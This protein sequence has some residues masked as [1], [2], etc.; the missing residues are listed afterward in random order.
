MPERLAAVVVM[1]AVACRAPVARLASPCV[2]TSEAIVVAANLDDDDRDGRIDGLQEPP[3]STDDEVHALGVSGDCQLR[4]DGAPTGEVRLWKGLDGGSPYRVDVVRGRSPSWNGVASITAPG[5]GSITLT[6]PPILLRNPNEP[7]RE[8]WVTDVTDPAF[9]ATHE[10]TLRLEAALPKPVT[11]R[12]LS[13]GGSRA[14]RWVQDAFQSAS[15]G[16]RAAVVRLPRGGPT[17]GLELLTHGDGLPADV[18]TVG[19]GVVADSRFDYGG[20]LEVLAPFDGFLNGR[21]VIGGPLDGQA[22]PVSPGLLAWL[23]AQGAQVPAIRLPTSWLVS[24]HV[25]DVVLPLPSTPGTIRV[26]LA[27]TTAGLEAVKGTAPKAWKTRAFLDFNRRCQAHLDA[28]E[29]ALRAGVAPATLR[30]VHLPV[31]FAERTS[32]DAGLATSVVPNPV[33]ALVVD[34]TVFVGEPDAGAAG[35]ALKAAADAQLRDAG[36]TPQWL[37]VSAYASRGGS[38]HCAVEAIR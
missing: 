33:N 5:A 13:G 11:V 26:A 28:A 19:T 8:V 32:A 1:M 18:G 14:D 9:D 29:A 25:D 12:R 36:F 6:T 15:V 37:E 34:G 10:F 22:D 27:S 30:V 21:A 3:S 16:G 35:L 2:V 38:V 4:I 20:N 24:G 23:D 7:I 17:R 31:L